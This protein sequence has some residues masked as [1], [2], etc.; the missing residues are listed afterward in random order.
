MST[1]ALSFGS[2]AR[3][4]DSIRPAYPAQAVARAIGSEPVRVLDLGA[5]TGLLTRVLRAAGHEVIAV[6]PD[7]QM[8]VVAAERHPGTQ[9]LAG[10]AEDIPLPDGSVDAV[11]VGQAY[12]WFTPQDALPQIHRVLR[13][14]GVFAPMW[15]VRDDRTP[16]VAALSG[17]IGTEGY[18]LESAWQY[19]PV[20]PWF[21]APELVLTE[22]TVTVPTDRL[23]DLVRSRSYYLTADAAER[24]RLDREVGELAATDPALAGRDSVE[25]PYRTCVYRML[26]V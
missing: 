8:R 17:V 14:D 26:R 6:E 16:W 21:T 20:T 9:V 18:G 25:M 13:K 19:G 2:A 10:S 5:G 4:Y 22:H 15:N 24:A 11:V 7:A 1:S 3:L 12:H 23:V